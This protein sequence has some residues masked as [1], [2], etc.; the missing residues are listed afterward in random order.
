MI[1]RVEFAARAVAEIGN[2]DTWYEE[3]R[4]GLGE[5]FAVEVLRAIQ[6][7]QANPA[8]FPMVRR[9]DKMRRVLTARFPY[10]VMFSA[11]DDAIVVYAILHC[12]RNNRRMR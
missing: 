12:A 6:R 1:R 7:A 9:R 10:K 3:Q 11:Q 5:E 8:L 4:E 2:A